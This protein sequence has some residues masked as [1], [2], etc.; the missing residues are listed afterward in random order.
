MTVVLGATAWATTSWT[1]SE[2]AVAVAGWPTVEVP[3]PVTEERGR[4]GA[5]EDGRDEDDSA[6]PRRTWK[7]ALEDHDPATRPA[8]QWAFL[9]QATDDGCRE[10][11]AKTKARFQALPDQDAPN[12]QGCGI[13]RGV[14]LTVGP[15]GVGYSPPLRVDCS[16]ALRLA[17]IEAILHEEAERA[18][19][20]NVIRV[21]TRGSYNCRGVVGRLRGWS[22]GISEHGLGN[23]VDVAHVDLASG[24]RVSVLA[25]YPDG[26]KAEGKMLRAVVRRIWEEAD[27]RALGPE[28]DRAHRDHLHVDAGSRWWR[29]K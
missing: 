26:S 12:A 7:E 1:A 18:F 27:M 23:A 16:L 14:L 11:L 9:E 17:E 25:H 19:E 10:R 13:P 8:K 20:Q 6:E 3:A 28:F 15:T 29:W 22:G 4:G 2:A 24:K 21:G 5:E